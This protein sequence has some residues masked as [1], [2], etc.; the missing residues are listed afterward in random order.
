MGRDKI[1][2]EKT[3]VATRPPAKAAATAHSPRHSERH[4]GRSV[5]LSTLEWSGVSRV[6]VGAQLPTRGADGRRGTATS[7]GHAEPVHGQPDR[8]DGR[9]IAVWVLV[10]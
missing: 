10:P 2:V 6:R 7:S 8:R 3:I 1:T 4:R 9:R 5:L